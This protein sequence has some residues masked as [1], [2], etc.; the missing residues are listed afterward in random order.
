[1][2]DYTRRWKEQTRERRGQQHSM[3]PCIWQNPQQEKLL[4]YNGD[5]TS[6]SRAALSNT[7]QITMC[8]HQQ[9][10]CTAAA[11]GHTVSQKKKIYTHVCLYF[12][13]SWDIEKREDIEQKAINISTIF[14]S[15]FFLNW[16]VSRYIIQNDVY[17]R[18]EYD[19]ICVVLFN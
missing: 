18:M 15:L 4:I 3:A 12:W 2:L 8:A 5:R 6:I 7:T 11:R 10:R 9:L 16:M 13:Y 19:L 17:Y 14:Q 1:M